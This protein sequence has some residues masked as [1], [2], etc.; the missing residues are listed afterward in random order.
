MNILV[1][2]R[3][4]IEAGI[5]VRSSYVVISIHDPDKKKPLIRKQSGLRAVLSL[6]FHDA[7]PSKGMT[8]PENITLMTKEQATLI[9]EFVRE[10]NGKVG[11]V[12]VHCEQGMSRS[13]AI[14]AAVSKSLGLDEQPFHKQYQPN[15]YVYRLVV[16]A[17]SKAIPV[18]TAPLP[19]PAES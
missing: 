8:L 14:A 2:D 5:L 17:W 4:S 19:G 12:V 6:A 3:D 18:A 9:C 13:P 16:E 11:S 10:W 1:T 15:R 7:E